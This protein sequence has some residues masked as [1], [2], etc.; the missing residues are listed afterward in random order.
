MD[1]ACMICQEPVFNP[2]LDFGSSQIYRCRKCGLGKR[3][4]FV[5]KSGYG[6]D[7]AGRVGRYEVWER[8]YNRIYGLLERFKEPGNLLDIGCAEG[9]SL[10][11]GQK[12]GWEAEGIEVSQKAVDF[13]K[14]H[15]GLDIKRGDFEAID[16]FG[17]K[18]YDV[19]VLNHL[20]EHLES[21]KSALVKARTLLKDGG[22]VF[23]GTPNV[24]SFWAK[25]L[26]ERWFPWQPE[27]HLWHFQM[28]HLNSL[29]KSAGFGPVYRSS[30]AIFEPYVSLRKRIKE[31]ASVVLAP[32]GLGEGLVVIGEKR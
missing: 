31:T 13:G 8:I 15:F 11:I 22:L 7:F 25:L 10:L 21:P 23:V 26:R 17:R 12:R 1:E 20:L 9:T 3:V 5:L 27:Q 19:V 14:K 4:P 16:D 32:F 28:K 24:D 29:L 2:F 6:D 30:V 18:H